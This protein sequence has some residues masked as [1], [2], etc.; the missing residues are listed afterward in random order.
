MIQ[1]N[2]RKRKENE[3]I[4]KF[5]FSSL[6]HENANDHRVGDRQKNKENKSV[7]GPGNPNQKE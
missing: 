2:I 4:F 7:L 6:L 3:L 5:T 1:L